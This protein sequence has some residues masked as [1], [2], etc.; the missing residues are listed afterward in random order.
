MTSQLFAIVIT[1]GVE[2]P[3]NWLLLT[4][5]GPDSEA[6]DNALWACCEGT[7]HL[8]EDGRDCTH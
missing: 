7:N 6:E 2:P 3:V 1:E 4:G 8:W 5:S